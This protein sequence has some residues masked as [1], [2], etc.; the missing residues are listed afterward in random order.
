MKSTSAARRPW[1]FLFLLGA[2]FLGSRLL[3][4][5][6]PQPTSD[7]FVYAQYVHEYELSIRQRVPFYE[8][9]ARGIDEQ[10]DKARKAGRLAGSL[11]EY[12]NVEYPPLALLFI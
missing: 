6:Y 10:A 4:L 7:V 3:L 2:A 1:L 12:K 9:H 11:D 5:P 8:L